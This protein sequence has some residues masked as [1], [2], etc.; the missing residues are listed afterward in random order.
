MVLARTVI[1]VP[2]LIKYTS[3][4]LL[5]PS[6]LQSAARRGGHE[7][8]IL[9]LNAHFLHSR[10]PKRTKHGVFIGDHDKPVGENSLNEIEK[11]FMSKYILPGLCREI[12]YAGD[13]DALQRRV[14]FGFLTHEE[15][16]TAATAMLS[17][18]FG[19]WARRA[20]SQHQQLTP[21]VVGVSL[22]HAGQVIPATALSMM[23]RMLW[24]DSLVVWGGPH[25]SGLG[26]KTLSED[27]R[28]RSFAADLFV[29][30]HAE[31]TFVDILDDVARGGYTSRGVPL[32]VSGTR[33]ATTFSPTFD[34]DNLDLYDSPLTLPAQSSL[35]CSYGKCAF[36]TYPAIEP[37]PSRLGLETSVGVVADM[38]N[39][40]GAS[41]SIKDSLVTS[42]RLCEIGDC[43]ANRAQWSACTKLSSRL[44]LDTL[45]GLRLSGLATLEVGLESLLPETQKR[46]GKVQP[47]SLYEEL[48]SNVAKVPGLTLVVNYMTGFPWEQSQEALAKRE[49]ARAI[50]SRHLGTKRARIESNEFE[51]ER[52]APMARSPERYDI[53]MRSVKSWPWASVL[54]WQK[55]A[56]TSR[57]NP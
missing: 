11:E 30:G 51:L 21:D 45:S 12:D 44:D 38:A 28:Q 10:A 33:G 53:D 5:G 57:R 49:E 15:I 16:Q 34:E 9:D 31:K 19:T 27:L 18:S 55:Q 43:I 1:I 13:D 54:E 14:K 8:S 23:A 36:C 50:L 48:V 39:K 4:P 7:C 35:G 37:T 17:S 29:T 47:Q 40:L 42:R 41:V 6:L 20:I 2:P 26:E 25:I 56:A 24:P 52:L 46:I 3:G 22:L 32:V